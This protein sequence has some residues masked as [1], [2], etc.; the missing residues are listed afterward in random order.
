MYYLFIPTC[1]IQI[2]LI[3]IHRCDCMML[4]VCQVIEY[5][6]LYSNKTDSKI[7]VRIFRHVHKIAKSDY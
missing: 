2:L 5:S 4:L 7:F 3:Y 6:I 1:F